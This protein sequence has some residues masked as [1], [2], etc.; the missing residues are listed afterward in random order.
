MKKRLLLFSLAIS[1]SAIAQQDVERDR[2]TGLVMD[3]GFEEVRANCTVCHSAAIIVQSR[4]SRESWQESIRWM[5]ETQG[6]WPLTVNEPIILDYL[7]KHYPPNETGRR[8]N[9][10][11]NQVPKLGS[12]VNTDFSP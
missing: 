4:L 8:Q 6:L 11:S 5:Q 10:P 2:A 12:A 7:A 9:L 3:K 1:C